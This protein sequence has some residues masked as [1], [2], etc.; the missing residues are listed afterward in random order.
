MSK[1]VVV[2]DDHSLIAEALSNI[3]EKFRG[4]RVLYEAENGKALIEKFKH[5]Q[6][7]PDIVLLDINMPVMDGFETAKW[8]RQHHPEVHII[9]LSMQDKEDTLIKIVRC[10]ARGYLLKNIHANELERALET[11]VE[12]GYYYPDWVTH[13]VL[14]N[15]SG[16]EKASPIADLNDRELEFLRYAATELTYKEISDKMNCSPRTVEGYRDNLFEKFQLKTRV[17]LVLYAIR[18]QLINLE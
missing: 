11:I 15:I 13:K 1:S 6:N 18:H 4:F 17:G 16:G 7:V 14:L 5:P 3:I 12:K 9:A 2:V 10:G 8:I